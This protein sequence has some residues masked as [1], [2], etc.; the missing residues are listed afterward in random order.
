[1][2]T[3]QVAEGRPAVVT[4]D[5]HRGHLDPA[6]ATMPLAADAAARVTEA[7]ANLLAGAR[8]RGIP[9]VHVVTSYHDVS[10][11]ASNPW[12]ARVAGTSATRANVLKHQLPESP[13]LQV[14]PQL[15]DPGYDIVVYN[16]K[17]YDAFVATELDH[18]L[19]SRGVETLLLT[20]VNT[21][22]CVLAT[23]VAANS[24]D[25]RPIV[26]EDCVDT[27]DPSLHDPA[28]AVIRQAFG[29]TATVKEVLDAL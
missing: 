1:M 11:I 19:R 8:T 16:K 24:R 10:E 15:L 3:A 21:N 27:M 25:Y 13:G 14:M 4:I 6:V 5:L 26:V 20:G 23:T 18:V 2:T 29:W 17:R 9:V 12:W 22:S 28:L 7:N